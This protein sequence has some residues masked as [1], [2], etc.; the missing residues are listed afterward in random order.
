VTRWL[1]FLELA[2]LAALAFATAT[3]LA[4]AVLWPLLRRGLAGRHPA[5]AAR[6]L[7]LAAVAPVV[8]PLLG[9]ALCLLPGLLGADHCPIHGGHPHL[10]L[11]HPAVAL[12]GGASAL[13]VASAGA[14]ALGLLGGA[15]RLAGERRVLT[16]LGRGAPAPFATDVCVLAAEVP[17]SFCLGAFRPRIV[18]SDGLVR[19]LPPDSL[20]V[21][22][23][24]ER[25]HA[26]RRDA[27]RGLLARACARLHL[28]W[29]RRGLLDALALATERTCDEAAAKN[30][31]DRLLV[32]ETIL[33]VERLLARAPR[34]ALAAAF[35]DAAVPRRIEG[36]LDEPGPPVEARRPWL[37]AATVVATAIPLVEPLHHGTEHLLGLLLTWL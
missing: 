12:G 26:R 18:L 21:V 9:I 23:E 32:A 6:W 19:A 20:A 2:T 30:I 29:V 34:N 15:R 8:A 28:P 17:L 27:L 5:S 13:V 4:C 7:W 14:L 16:G 1:G 22:L 25:A 11:H 36:L 33:A 10:C 24:H 3:S 37:G 35:G 31:G